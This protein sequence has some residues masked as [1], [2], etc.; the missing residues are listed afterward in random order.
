MPWKLIFYL[1]VVGLILVFV[2]VN[3]G[4]TT[5]ISL[6]FVVYEEVPVFMALFVAFF[7]GVAVSIPIAVQSSSRKTKARSER[8]REK[9]ERKRIKREE[10][11][12][13]PRGGITRLLPG[14]S[15]KRS[16]TGN[17]AEPAE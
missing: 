5:D 10:R 1:V 11:D 14:S 12:A 17:T 6:G 13:R 4:N 9:A 2:G 8:K 7:L 16:D 3:L 15:K